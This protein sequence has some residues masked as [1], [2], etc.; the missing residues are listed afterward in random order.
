MRQTLRCR[1]YYYMMYIEKSGIIYGL[2]RENIG[3]AQKIVNKIIEFLN[4]PEPEIKGF[5]IDKNR[6]GFSESKA[7]VFKI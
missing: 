1:I 3:W 6:V 5:L 7:D 2:F 4:K